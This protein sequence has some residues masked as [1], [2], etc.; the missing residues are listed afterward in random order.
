LKAAAA[1]AVFALSAAPGRAVDVEAIPPILRRSREGVF[2]AEQR[3]SDGGLLVVGGLTSGG[4]GDLLLHGSCDR[5]LEPSSLRTSLVGAVSGEFSLVSMQASSILAARDPLGAKPMYHGGAPG[6]AVVSTEPSVIASFSAQPAPTPPGHLLELK[7]GTLKSTTYCSDLPGEPFVGDLDRAAGSVGDLLRSSLR[8]RLGTGG[9][10]AVAFSGGLDSSLLAHSCSKDHR[11]VL[12]S[13]FASGSR[14]EARVHGAADE[15]GLELVAVKV[16]RSE[17]SAAPGGGD[18]RSA[19]TSPMD[20]A[21]SAGFYLASAA[22]KGQ[23]LGR[24][25]AGQGADEIFGGYNRHLELASADPAGLNR[26]MLDELPLLEAGLR[27]DELAIVRGGCEASFPYADLP[28]AMFALSLPP[29][30]LVSHRERKLVL[31]RAAAETGL[32]PS[33]ASAEKKAFQYSSGIQSLLTAGG[34]PN[35]HRFA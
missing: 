19:G 7:R 25:V 35:D 15:L 2:F 31:R 33:M 6:L 27:R 24:L 34:R 13:V 14:D 9:A 26:R 11:V 28:L 23:G 30:Y 16:G 3:S 5:D 17:V 12:I 10:V 32:P 21:L 29:S 22:A 8:V 4:G 18:G 1:S 20:R